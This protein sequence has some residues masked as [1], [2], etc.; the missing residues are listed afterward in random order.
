M[1]GLV[2][3]S[4]LSIYWKSVSFIA[5]NFLWPIGF[6]LNFSCAEML[7]DV[8]WK[9]DINWHGARSQ[10]DFRISLESCFHWSPQLY[11]LTSWKVSS[12][13]QFC[14]LM[15][16]KDFRSSQLHFLMS[17]KTSFSLNLHHLF[18][19]EVF[20]KSLHLWLQMS[21]KSSSKIHNS[22]TWRQ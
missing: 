11:L 7:F 14:L 18:V 10:E 2:G 3:V 21:G 9:F 20:F 22:I 19:T 13:S 4:S 8:R 17:G 5:E 15:S 6:L 1:S 16:G 12:S